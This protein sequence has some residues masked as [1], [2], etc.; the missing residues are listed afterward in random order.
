MAQVTVQQL[1]EVVGTPV[2]KLLEQLKDAGLSFDTP[3]QEISDS[4]KLQLLEHLRQSKGAK[5]GGSASGDGK[6][7]T[8]RR[9]STSQLK[10]SGG[11]GRSAGT[12]TVNV[13]V[14]R[15]KTY[16]KRSELIEEQEQK[17]KEEEA[18]LEQQRLAE[19]QKE[20]EMQQSMSFK[21]YVMQH[22]VEKKQA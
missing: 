14:R 2:D 1:A 8:L 5:L 19:E 13:E 21:Q 6:K 17:R 3:D 16:V 4:E 10:V 22:E 20:K 7:I 9:K 12:K 11:Q 18:A 15:K